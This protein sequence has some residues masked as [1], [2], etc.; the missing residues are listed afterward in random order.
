MGLREVK[1]ELSKLDK[2]TLIK[3]ISELYKKYK[4][5]KEYFDFYV[6]PIEKKILDQY[7]EKV[8]EGFF[9]KRGYQLKL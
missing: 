1:S 2:A 7:K 6:D 5:V 3:H 9:P 4:P 8:T